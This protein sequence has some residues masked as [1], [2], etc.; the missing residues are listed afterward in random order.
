MNFS[1]LSRSAKLLILLWV[2][3][4]LFGSGE[5]DRPALRELRRG[6][7]D[8]LEQAGRAGASREDVIRLRKEAA[9]RLEAL[10]REPET[11]ASAAVLPAELRAELRRAASELAAAPPPGDSRF[12]P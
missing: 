5:A 7:A 2:V 10:G 8:L 9:Q 11:A 4:P 1:G 6:A 3:V 12:D